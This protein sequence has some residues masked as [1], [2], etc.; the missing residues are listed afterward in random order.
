MANG[1]R[2]EASFANVSHVG[3][4]DK[5][6]LYR[7]AF[8]EEIGRGEACEVGS[9]RCVS[10]YPRAEVGEDVDTQT[11]AFIGASDHFKVRLL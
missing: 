3:S 5:I 10:L 6:Q 7:E 9:T 4:G 8:P 2:P 11:T 1:F